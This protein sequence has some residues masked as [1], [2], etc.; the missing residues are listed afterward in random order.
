[1]DWRVLP[2]AARANM[3]PSTVRVE[4]LYAKLKLAVSILALLNMIPVEIFILYTVL[5][6]MMMCGQ[7]PV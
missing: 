4:R 5:F 7:F 2:K 3:S 1:M 6:T